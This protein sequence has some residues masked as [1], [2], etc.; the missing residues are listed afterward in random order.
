MTERQYKAKIAEIENKIKTLHREMGVLNEEMR[1][2]AKTGE[3]SKINEKT[4]LFFAK[5]NESFVLMTERRALHC[6]VNQNGFTE[7]PECSTCDCYDPDMGCTMSSI[8]RIYACPYIDKDCRNKYCI[9]DRVVYLDDYNGTVVCVE[10]D[11]IVVFFDDA[12][13]SNIY[14]RYQFFTAN[15][16]DH[17]IVKI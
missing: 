11:F 8:D 14:D 12:P 7:E 2:C 13:E 1:Q 17:D 16:L 9:G 4:E 3:Y 10:E 15:E 6:E 5:S